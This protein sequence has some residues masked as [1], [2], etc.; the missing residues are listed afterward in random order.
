MAQW[1]G[2]RLFG[3]PLQVITEA[4]EIPADAFVFNYSNESLAQQHYQVKPNGLLHEEGIQQ[5]N[6]VIHHDAS[7]P[8]FYENAGG[9]HPFDVLAAAFFLISRYEEYY[10]D[11]EPD[12]YGR[13]SHTNSLAYKEGFLK[14]PLIDEWLEDL[15]ASLSNW[16]ESMLFTANQPTILATCDVDIAW[17]YRNKGIARTIG[18]HINDFLNMRWNNLLERWLVLAGLKR[19]PFEIFQE[20]EQAHQHHHIPSRYFFLLA[21]AQKGYDKNISP[22]NKKLQQLIRWLQGETGVGIHF[23]WNA[24]QHFDAMQ[25]EKDCLEKISGTRVISNR[26]HYINFRLPETMRQL[27]ATGMIEDYSMG[28]GT[29]NGFRAS[30]SHPFLWYD[31]QREAT[32]GLMIFPFAWMDANSIFEQKDSPGEALRELLELHDRVVK[33]GGLFITICHNHLIGLDAEGRKWWK[34][35]NQFLEACGSR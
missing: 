8:Y 22:R 11:Y 33:T 25:S 18:G 17:S 13:Y 32:T 21:A 14:R 23:S 12:E 3:K 9:D 19:D 1:L 26:M 28:Y 6:I 10:P 31:L 30:T 4:G 24:S 35:Y 20:L 7:I 15:K 16:F 2:M 29:I 27:V 34:G 5:Q